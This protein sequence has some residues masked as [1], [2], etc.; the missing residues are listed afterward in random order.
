MDDAMAKMEWIKALFCEI[1]IPGTCVN[2]GS[3]YG[4]D[5][6]CTIVKMGDDQDETLSVTDATFSTS[7]LGR[8]VCAGGLSWMWP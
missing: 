5:E 3:Q 2:D 6:T 1:A 8:L 7:G 4:P